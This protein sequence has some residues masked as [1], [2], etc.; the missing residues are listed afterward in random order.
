MA[1]MDL[2]EDKKD[3]KYE[4]NF[5]GSP[6]KERWFK[7]EDDGPTFMQPSVTEESSAGSS[8][9]NSVRR[10]GAKLFITDQ[11]SV[12]S[13]HKFVTQ[14]SHVLAQGMHVTDENP[15]RMKKYFGDESKTKFYDTYRE[16]KRQKLLLPIKK[17]KDGHVTSDLSFLVGLSI[18]DHPVNKSIADLISL[19]VIKPSQAKEKAAEKM[20][21]MA[22]E[23]FNVNSF[24]DA[25]VDSAD[26]DRDRDRD[27]E[28]HRDRRRGFDNM[29]MVP[30]GD[31]P[32]VRTDIDSVA[33]SL[34]SARR[35]QKANKD[36][37]SDDSVFSSD[38]EAEGNM[39]PLEPLFPFVSIFSN[40]KIS[41][42]RKSQASG[43][44]DMHEHSLES[45]A[46]H[47]IASIAAS[48]KMKSLKSDMR[49]EA[50]G[51][52]SKHMFM[53]PPASA[54]DRGSKDGITSDTGKRSLKGQDSKSP[55]P[56]SS[57]NVSNGRRRGDSGDI[58]DTTGTGA[59]GTGGGGGGGGNGPVS[60]RTSKG[61]GSVTRG[62]SAL[63]SAAPRT[64]GTPSKGAG[65]GA[66][67]G[68]NRRASTGA[69]PAVVDRSQSR[70]RNMKKQVSCMGRVDV[71]KKNANA[72]ASASAS[73]GKGISSIGNKAKLPAAASPPPS[74][75][76]PA[77]KF[78][79]QDEFLSFASDHPFDMTDLASSIDEDNEFSVTS[80]LPMIPQEESSDDE[81]II[82]G[83]DREGYITYG[84]DSPRAKFL[85]GCIDKR[86]PPRNALMLRAK[87]SS[88]L[89]LEHHG[90]GDGLA[91]LLAPALAAMP[92][93]SGV[94]IADNNLT[95]VGLEPIIDSI[96]QCPLVKEFDIS[97]NIIGPKAAAA[98]A[99]LLGN[100]LCKLSKI[101]L[102]KCDID[103][104]ECERFVD[105]L[106]TNK[107]LQELDMSDNLLGKDE[108][109]N[110]VKPDIVTAG[111]ALASLLREGGYMTCI[112]V[113]VLGIY[114]YIYIYGLT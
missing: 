92:L 69:K 85:A 34:T 18:E 24:M 56:G 15:D 114:I 96:G 99:K 62:H 112:W 73:V 97:E 23:L 32:F 58:S 20:A 64:A 95:D 98:L 45:T 101:T 33:S 83:G 77:R 27:R 113:Y 82:L 48:G 26:P 94:N 28:R 44:I 6:I 53:S 111:E 72:N 86:I 105:A 14:R 17:D 9:K 102:R 63:P 31:V 8:T 3:R 88:V 42:R 103:D 52:R 80:H 7:E 79:S 75:P 47:G 91:L 40:E 54:E 74:P 60:R 65:A 5:L 1:V 87:V 81:S 100:P 110:A 89:F 46:P 10:K 19:K 30:G 106:K 16:L 38:S 36:E 37:V 66:G 22:S 29:D 59:S 50:E 41:E 109:L 51:N 68:A 70:L 21:S 4:V 78:E 84:C 2:Y 108:N 11:N 93:V 61:G 107:H 35:R 25:S 67:V 49:M 43:I 76:L 13:T 104:G 71:G 39:S 57:S 12:S 55:H 90:M